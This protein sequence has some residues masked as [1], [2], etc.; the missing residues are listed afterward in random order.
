MNDLTVN[1]QLT[2]DEISLILNSIHYTISIKSTKDSFHTKELK[3]LY[4]KLNTFVFPISFS[5]E[6]EI[7]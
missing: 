5:F 7:Q 6:D 1:V 4:E 3:K 2:P